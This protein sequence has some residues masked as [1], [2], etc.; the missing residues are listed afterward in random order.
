LGLDW[1]VAQRD[2]KAQPLPPKLNATWTLF[3]LG[4]GVLNALRTVLI[5]ALLSI[6]PTSMFPGEGLGLE[7]LILVGGVDF[8]AVGPL[9][10]LAL[11]RWDRQFALAV[12]LAEVEPNS[13]A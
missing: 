5:W 2:G 10:L 11:W 6:E 3:L 12:G 4:L 13:T 7:I 9:W 8:V 1:A